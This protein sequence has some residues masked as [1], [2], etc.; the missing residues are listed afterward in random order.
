MNFDCPKCGKPISAEDGKAGQEMTCPECKAA[1]AVPAGPGTGEMAE[2]LFKNAVAAI[3][4]DAVVDEREKTVLE[5]ARRLLDI[6]PGVAKHWIREVG[7][8][9]TGIMR[10]ASPQV[11]DH[12]LNL[13]IAACKV[14]GIIR[15]RERK[16][17]EKTAADFGI[18]AGELADRLHTVTFA[19]VHD[20]LNRFL[21]H[22]GGGAGS[23]GAPTQ[24]PPAK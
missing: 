20:E 21:G 24:D 12:S 23:S 1:I 5:R 3:L 11:R 2:V 16:L 10:S 4:A 6:E 18:P 17:L 8:D 15:G 9:P 14:D 7:K 13:M 19:S 22:A